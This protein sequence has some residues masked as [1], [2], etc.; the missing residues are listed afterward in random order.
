MGDDRERGRVG[1]LNLRGVEDIFVV[2]LRDAEE[3]RMEVIT[4]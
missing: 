4:G 2:R 3:W 1:A